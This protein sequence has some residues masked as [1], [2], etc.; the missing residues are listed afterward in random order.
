[1]KK[2][3][4]SLIVG[5]TLVLPTIAMAAPVNNSDLM[6]ADMRN[7]AVE[8]TVQAEIEGPDGELL[9]T[10]PGA[11][12]V[13]ESNTADVD[14]NMANEADEMNDET[15]DM[16]NEA[17][18]DNASLMNNAQATTNAAA[19][20]TAQAPVQNAQAPNMQHSNADYQPL[21]AGEAATENKVA[22]AASTLQEK[23]K[24]KR[25]ELLATQP[26]NVQFK[27]NR[28]IAVSR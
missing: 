9:A 22:D 3:V 2:N 5:A 20:T 1:M 16:D 24:D 10:Q 14:M 4:L 12:D 8:S 21:I 18:D 6:P 27:E 11:V 25:G 7:A 15:D 28:R 26:A 17:S 23:K 13:E 19:M